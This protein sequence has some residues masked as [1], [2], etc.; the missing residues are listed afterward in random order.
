M[1]FDTES[2][3]KWFKREQRDLPW[4]QDRTPYAVWISEMMLQQTQVS[5]VIPY[6]ER[7]MKRFPTVASL[8]AA[9]LDDVIKT[10]EGLGYYSRARYIHSG[11]KQIVEQHHG[12]FPS[13]HD[14]LS[15]IKG[16]GPYTVGAIRSFAFQQRAPAV[17][18]NVIRVLSRYFMIQDDVSKPA[19]I[20]NIWNL[21]EGLLPVK[22]PWEINEALIELGA[23]ICTRKAKCQECPIRSSCKAFA[24]GKVD[25]LPFKSA[26]T[27]IESLFRAVA[28]IR[29]D[30]KILVRRGVQGE[31]MSDLHEFPYF[32]ITADGI[33]QDSFQEKVNN[34]LGSKVVF[35]QNLPDVAHSFT[36]FRVKLT[37]MEFISEAKRLPKVEP[38]YQWLTMLEISNLAFSS[39]H[40]RVL[41]ELIS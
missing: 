18:G 11:A 23:T 2:L 17:D 32:E 36:R 5:V 37:S 3:R 12:I 16:L 1:S 10:W 8:A 27:K 41:S 24:N 39:G 22:A 40:R 9:S 6:F 4:R 15:K 19:T 14:Q 38:G 26:K 25:Q 35:E 31:I 33:D 29:H 28:V 21:A 20:K 30:N 7:W 34:W 13:D